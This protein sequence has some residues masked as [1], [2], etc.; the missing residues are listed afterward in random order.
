MIID[1]PMQ[2]SAVKANHHT[3]QNQEVRE[4]YT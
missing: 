3:K 1:W 2:T 4:P